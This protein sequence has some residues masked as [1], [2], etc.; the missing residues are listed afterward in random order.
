[1]NTAD[2]PNLKLIGIN[3]LKSKIW[4]TIGRATIMLQQY[5]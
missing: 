5:Q 4:G 1:M 3:L 2:M